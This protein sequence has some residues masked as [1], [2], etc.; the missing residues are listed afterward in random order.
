VA[1]IAAGEVIERTGSVAKELIENALDAGSTRIVVEYDDRDRRRIAVADDGAGIEPE[2]VELALTRHA[3]SKIRTFDDL[4][5]IAS[6]GFRGEALASIAAVAEV[7]LTTRARGRDEAASVLVRGGKCLDCSERAF[8]QGTRVDVRNL[9]AEM[10]AREKFLKTASTEFSV[11]ADRVRCYALGYPAVGFFLMH[12]GREVFSYAG[13]ADLASRVSQVLGPENAG[14]MLPVRATHGSMQLEG[15]TSA[16]GLSHGSNRWISWFVNR[17]W[18]RDRLLFRALTDAYKTYLVRGK[19]PAS[20]LF[21][22]V[23]TAEVDVNVHPA[24][25]EVRF[26]D[27]KAVGGFIVEALRDCLRTGASPL[28]RWGAESSGFEVKEAV[29]RMRGMRRGA[30][31]PTRVR[32]GSPRVESMD[33]ETAKIPVS[34]RGQAPPPGYKQPAP[35]VPPGTT[36][37]VQPRLMPGDRAGDEKLVALE[38]VGQVLD[39]YIV[40]RGAECL[41]L[42]DQHAAHERLLFE[43]LM[44]ARAGVRP[45]TQPLLVPVVVELGE[46]GTEAVMANREWLAQAGWRVDAL[47]PRGVIVREQ[48]ALS[49]NADARVLIEAVAA[50]LVEAGRT[51]AVDRSIE[52]VMATIACHAAIRVGQRLSADAARDLL[53]EVADVEFSACCPHGR[54]VARTLSRERVER[55]FDR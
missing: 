47:G 55:L 41:V 3:T 9:F 34:V 36:A 8:S 1:K 29:Y 49:A 4:Q 46:A 19:Y 22:G 27:P 17:R 24:K 32:A 13:V 53:R 11:L 5:S 10:P 43:R 30:A 26:G 31:A 14:V 12:N 6:L 28:G 42:V 39:G 37:A 50:D 20:V 54:P 23:S 7:E 2:Q 15:Y 51:K 21:L 52:R 40:C 45:A 35:E 44:A 18:V 48:P 33:E 25:T 16:P 38:V